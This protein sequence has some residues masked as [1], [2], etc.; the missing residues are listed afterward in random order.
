MEMYS[1][2]GF[3]VSNINS[4]DSCGFSSSKQKKYQIP[5]SANQQLEKHKFA[6]KLQQKCGYPLRQPHNCCNSGIYPCPRID[7]ENSK[8]HTIQWMWCARI[9]STSAR[10]KW[11]VCQRSS[12]FIVAFEAIVTLF[13]VLTQARELICQ[14]CIGIIRCRWSCR[15]A[16]AVGWRFPMSRLS[17]PTSPKSHNSISYCPTNWICRLSLYCACHHLAVVRIF[18]AHSLPFDLLHCSYKI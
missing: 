17:R 10:G 9:Q 5:Q 7:F 14:Y 13:T 3:F 4:I 8:T 1:T 16:T 6:N 15:W 18:P 2:F 11:M 12:R